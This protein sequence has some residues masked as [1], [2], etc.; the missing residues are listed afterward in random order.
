MKHQDSSRELAPGPSAAEPTASDGGKLLTRH[1]AARRLGIS[2]TTLRRRERDVLKPVMVDGVHMFEER[3]VR[4]V[5]TTLRRKLGGSTAAADGGVAAD[6]FE[7]LRDGVQPVE[8]V[9]RLRLPPD[10]VNRLCEQ[11][12]AMRGGFMVSAE[13]ATALGG[14]TSTDELAALVGRVPRPPGK[15][16]CF[17]CGCDPEGDSYRVCSACLVG[18]RVE[19]RSHD[20]A[21][22]VRAVFSGSDGNSYGDWVDVPSTAD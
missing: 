4:S 9:M 3:Q 2:E 8:I 22:H 6:V 13:D 18:M 21:E 5:V 1:E 12:S 7:L 15:P 17:G 11:W 19:H 20:G 14:L 16:R 10:V